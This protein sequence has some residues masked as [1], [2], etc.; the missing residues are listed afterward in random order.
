MVTPAISISALPGS[1]ALGI[2][3]N[4][5]VGV[6]SRIKNPLHL[7]KELE[8]KNS[9]AGKNMYTSHSPFYYLNVYCVKR[10]RTLPFNFGF[11]F[12]EINLTEKYFRLLVR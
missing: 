5:W 9:G 2:T 4:P 10:L 1:A 6:S 12:T 8:H 3:A 11:L 7:R